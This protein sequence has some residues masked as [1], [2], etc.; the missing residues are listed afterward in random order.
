[1]SNNTF[2]QELYYPSVVRF[3][4]GNTGIDMVVDG[5]TTPQSYDLTP[6]DDHIFTVWDIKFSFVA[7][8]QTFFGGGRVPR[9]AYDSFMDD[10]ALV[11]GFT[12]EDHRVEGLRFSATVQ[13]NYDMTQLPVATW[14]I[15]G[16][17]ADKC[18]VEI[19]FNFNSNTPVILNHEQ[20]DF[21]RII[22]ND[23]MSNLEFFRASARGTTYRI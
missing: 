10:V 8:W 11:N 20:G 7:T 2:S 21:N 17:D 6:P 15:V 14:N 22:I 1:M 12:V 18:M 4:V 3:F 9:V 13:T 16:H 23:N 19:I 5:S